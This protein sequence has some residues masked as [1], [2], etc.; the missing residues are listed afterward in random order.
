MQIVKQQSPTAFPHVYLKER[1]P[2]V[3][4]PPFQAQDLSVSDDSRRR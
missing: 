2:G 1:S 4:L 3:V